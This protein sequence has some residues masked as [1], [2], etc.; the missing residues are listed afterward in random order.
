M[1]SLNR[2]I[3]RIAWSLGTRQWALLTVLCLVTL[4]LLGQRPAGEVAAFVPMIQG[5]DK[6]LHFTAYAGLA[7]CVFR[8]IYPFDPRI[9]IRGAFAWVPVILLPAAVGAVDEWMQGLTGSRATDLADWTM[10][11]LGATA[12]CVGGLAMRAHA[13]SLLARRS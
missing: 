11:V 6:I 9:E 8:S 2:L 5:L 4:I 12:V 10:D 13:R 1:S 7:V 3:D